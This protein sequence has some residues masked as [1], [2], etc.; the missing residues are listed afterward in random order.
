[1]GSIEPKLQTLS[2]G[3]LDISMMLGC[4]L[5]TYKIPE[6]CDGILAVTDQLRS[7]LCAVVLFAFNI[8]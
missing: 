8:G 5:F 3:F 4:L 1:M 7:R 6:V 2:I